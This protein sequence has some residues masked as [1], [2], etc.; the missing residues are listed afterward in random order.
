VDDWGLAFYTSFD[1]NILNE[2]V[3]I[4]KDGNVG[5]GTTSPSSA[6]HV[7]GDLNVTGTSYLGDVTLTSDNITV[8]N[9]LSRDGSISFFNNT[10]GETVR[11]TQG[12][13]V[14]IGTASPIAKLDIRVTGDGTSILNLNTERR[15]EFQ[16]EGS[17][18]GSQLRLR[19]T[20]G[21]NKI[22]YIDTNGKT[23]GTGVLC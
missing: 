14:G 6:L 4:D 18:S 13:N 11:I 10:G 22:L 19:N 12:G 2:V 8:N 5:I 23:L 1:N 7:V 3:R 20:L 9:I 16:Q 17:G 21:V 15:W